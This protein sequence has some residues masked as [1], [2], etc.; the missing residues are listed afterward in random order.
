MYTKDNCQSHYSSIM[1]YNKYSLYALSVGAFQSA[2]YVCVC[3]TCVKVIMIVL[4]LLYIFSLNIGLKVVLSPEE[5]HYPQYR[6]TVVLGT[7]ATSLPKKL[8]MTCCRNEI[9]CR[10]T[11]TTYVCCLFIIV[12]ETVYSSHSTYVCVHNLRA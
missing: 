12:N 8:A 7:N 5:V 3:S 6:Y 10:Y 2:M 4:H 1:T 11:V 9:I